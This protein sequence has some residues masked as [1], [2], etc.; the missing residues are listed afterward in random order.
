[1]DTVTDPIRLDLSGSALQV[2]H[3]W[4]YEEQSAEHDIASID[5]H[6]V[7]FIHGGILLFHQWF[8]QIKWFGLHLAHLNG[9]HLDNCANEDH[10]EWDEYQSSGALKDHDPTHLLVAT[11]AMTNSWS[12]S[13][14]PSHCETNLWYSGS[15]Q[16][17][18]FRETNNENYRQQCVLTW[19]LE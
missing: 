11:T 3:V 2:L 8:L 5:S 6:D 19:L 13:A 16:S 9:N 4:S 14:H 17:W 18:H 7:C 1:M 10:P 12:N 15:W